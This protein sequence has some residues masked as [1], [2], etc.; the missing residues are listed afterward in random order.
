MS[1]VCCAR[2]NWHRSP[3]VPSVQVHLY[4]VPKSV[5]SPPFSQGLLRQM[6][7]LAETHQTKT[8]ILYFL[9]SMSR[10]EW[11]VIPWEQSLPVNPGK[12]WHWAP[13]TSAEHLPPSQSS[14]TALAP[15]MFQHHQFILSR[16]M[17]RLPQIDRHLRN[18]TKKYNNKHKKK[19]Q[20][21]LRNLHVHLILH[22]LLN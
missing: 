9:L 19:N 7:T 2:V 14:H 8:C 3:H 18:L 11:I 20:I 1:V 6:P 22:M 17:N 10:Q 21:F 13:A 15:E 4:S 16:A 5:H 12:H